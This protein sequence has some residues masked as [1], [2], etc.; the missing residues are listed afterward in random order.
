MPS[1]LKISDGTTTV[2]FVSSTSGYAVTRWNPAVSRRRDNL[3]GG[4]GP[5]ED[6]YEEMEI[7]INGTDALT[8]LS[9]LQSL[10]DQAARW[11]K[12]EPTTAVLLHYQPESTSTELKSTILGP[13]DRDMIQLPGNFPDSPVF[14][15]IDPVVL[16]FKRLGL[17]LG[18]SVTATS[19][20]VTHPTTAAI[21]LTTSVSI[22]SPVVLKV[23]DAA[24]SDAGMND[25]YILMVSGAT[26]T[27]ASSRL[28]IMEAEELTTTAYTTNASTGNLPRGSAVLRYTPTSTAFVASAAEDVS[29]TADQSMKRWGIFINYRNNST[30][31][32]YQVRALLNSNE[33]TPALTIATGTSLPTW[34]FLGSLPV[35]RPMLTVALEVAATATGGTIDFDAMALMAMDGRATPNVVAPIKKDTATNFATYDGT[36]DHRLLTHNGPLVWINA[37]LGEG[38]GWKGDAVF[39]M[40]GA[41]VAAA[42]LAT[43]S[44]YWRETH[45]TTAAVSSVFVVQ[46]YQGRLTPQ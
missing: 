37:V 46:R 1:I 31:A 27:E 45:N 24:G 8:K 16:R 44:I 29:G 13:A 26:T 7:T 12:G 2:D 19:S 20:S 11:S 38:Q 25:S 17:W 22:D 43:D 39:T 34:A 28:I 14:D 9:T 35:D 41:A 4:R 6:V 40:R 33:R 10:L 3:L 42:W 32:G 36:V 23:E 18:E 30:T 21:S 15:Y 5:Y